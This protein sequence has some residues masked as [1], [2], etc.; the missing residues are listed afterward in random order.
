MNPVLHSSTCTNSS[1]D[2][3]EKGQ[4]RQIEGS[5]N[6]SQDLPNLDPTP[7]ACAISLCDIYRTCKSLKFRIR[8]VCLSRN[9]GLS[10]LLRPTRRQ[11]T[12]EDINS[13]TI[14]RTSTCLFSLLSGD[15]STDQIKSMSALR[16]SRD[17]PLSRIATK[18]LWST[19]NLVVSAHDY[20]CINKMS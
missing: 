1:A 8:E 5:P 14:Q 6:Q 19:A 15:T 2:G 11:R 12:A 4:I 7:R 18:T 10:R 16:V 3:M 13:E 9:L 17:L 20:Y